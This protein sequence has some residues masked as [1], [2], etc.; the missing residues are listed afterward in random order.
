MLAANGAG[1]LTQAVGRQQHAMNEELGALIKAAPHRL[2]TFGIRRAEI[3]YLT[4]RLIVVTNSIA[5]GDSFTQLSEII[6]SNAV[7]YS[8]RPTSPSLIEGGPFM[9]FYEQH[10]LLDADHLQMVPGGDGEVFKPP[11]KLKLLILD[12]SHIIAERFELG[13]YVGKHPE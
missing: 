6:C 7:D 5:R 13:E 4:L 9:E 1:S 8:I 10:P 11:L 2:Q 3:G 12:Q